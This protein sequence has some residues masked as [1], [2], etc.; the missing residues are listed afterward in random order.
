MSEKKV[1][2]GYARVSTHRQELGLEGQA[3]ALKE[4][5]RLFIEQESGANSHRPQLATIRYRLV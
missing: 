3:E 2:V 5:S 4:C 1:T